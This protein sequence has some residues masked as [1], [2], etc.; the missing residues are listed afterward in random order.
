MSRLLKEISL[1]TVGILGIFS[2]VTVVGLTLGLLFGTIK[3]AF[4][5][6]FRAWS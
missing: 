4:L 6:G 2:G 1:W 5:I 3:T